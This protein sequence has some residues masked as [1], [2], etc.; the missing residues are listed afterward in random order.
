[1]TQL[2]DSS[3]PPGFSLHQAGEDFPRQVSQGDNCFEYEGEKDM[4][5]SA[6]IF[7]QL[8]SGL[9]AASRGLFNVRS[10]IHPKKGVGGTV[11]CE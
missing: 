7:I 10:R 5:S 1:M 9:L 8:S 11:D 2:K 3:H 6:W 4:M